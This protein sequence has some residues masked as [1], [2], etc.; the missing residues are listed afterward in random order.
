MKLR[1]GDRVQA[2]GV[3]GTV[4]YVRYAAGMVPLELTMQT[5]PSPFDLMHPAPASVRRVA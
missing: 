5:G 4:T 2:N 1:V 3:R